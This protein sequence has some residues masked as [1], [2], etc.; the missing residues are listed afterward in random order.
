MFRYAFHSTSVL[1]SLYSMLISTASRVMA[2]SIWALKLPCSTSSDGRSTSGSATSSV[3][4]GVAF[5]FRATTAR[6]TG[7]LVVAGT[8]NSALTT[9]S[10]IS[11]N[12]SLVTVLLTRGNI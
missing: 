8:M 9:V 5:T 4:V 11:Y 2:I 7:T 10:G 12:R 3:I 6:M 1:T